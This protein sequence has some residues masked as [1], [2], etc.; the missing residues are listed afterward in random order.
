MD[1]T[2]QKFQRLL[3]VSRIL[4]ST[5]NLSE[6]L[7]KVM[8]LATEVADAETSSLLLYDEKT[9]E[10]V[11]DVAISDKE[12]QLKEIRLGLD[13]GIAGWVARERKPQIISDVSKEP[14]WQKRSDEKINFRTKSLLAVPMLYKGKLL[15]VIEAINKKKG[16]FNQ[17]DVQALEIFAIQ[18]CVAIENARIFE[19]LQEAKEKIEAVFTQM[20]DGAIFTD[21]GGRKLLANKSAEKLLGP[22]SISKDKL[23]EIFSEFHSSIPLGDLIALS[24]RSSLVDLSR[25]SG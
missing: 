2:A 22:E 14:R 13:E 16:D 25:A 24:E 4:S 12:S 17:E 23:P 7:H 19:S 3:E 1:I 11:F 21:S 20:S 10:L 5:L 18:A 8:S 6:L 15:G 9:N